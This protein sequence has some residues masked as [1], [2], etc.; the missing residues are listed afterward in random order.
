ML[1]WDRL[2]QSSWQDKKTIFL[3]FYAA[4]I[5][6]FFITARTSALIGAKVREQTAI[7][8]LVPVGADSGESTAVSWGNIA[9]NAVA[10]VAANLA[11]YIGNVI[12]P[13]QTLADKS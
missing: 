12:I 5:A 11:V 13:L 1:M 10:S 4:Y 3:I 9:V 2:V 8:N 6:A 7:G